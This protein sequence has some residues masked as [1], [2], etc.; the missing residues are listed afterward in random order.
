MAAMAK[1]RKNNVT[2][3]NVV[4]KIATYNRLQKFLVQLVREKETPRISFDEAIN[5]LLDRAERQ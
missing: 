3:R 5:E 1:P 2:A 4:L